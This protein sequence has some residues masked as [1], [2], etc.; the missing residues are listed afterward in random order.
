MWYI[1]LVINISSIKY[2]HSNFNFFLNIWAKAQ[3][4]KA[5][6]KYLIKIPCYAYNAPNAYYKK[7]SK[8]AT[9]TFETVRGQ[10]LVLHRFYVPQD[11]R[12]CTRHLEA[13]K[14]GILPSTEGP[15]VFC[16]LQAEDMVDS[17]REKVLCAHNDSSL[18]S[19]ACKVLAQDRFPGRVSW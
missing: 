11:T 18:V 14:R 3:R 8:I 12:C 16:A 15:T 4:I 2:N 6:I 17:M 7:C 13:L 9:K 10:V 1:E 5:S 19:W